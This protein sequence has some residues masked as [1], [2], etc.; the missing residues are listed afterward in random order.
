ME[1][2]FFEGVDCLDVL[3]FLNDNFLGFFSLGLLL[4]VVH[5]LL[6]Y[7]INFYENQRIK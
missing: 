5:A 7:S 3:T 4:F 2:K 6:I 1:V